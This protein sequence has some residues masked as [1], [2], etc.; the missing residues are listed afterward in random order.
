MKVSKK[1]ECSCIYSLMSLLW[2]Y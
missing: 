2:R 1:C